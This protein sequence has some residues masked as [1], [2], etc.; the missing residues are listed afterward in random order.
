MDQGSRIKLTSNCYTWLLRRWWL[1]LYC[2]QD[3]R[4]CRKMIN[5]DI[6]IN[7]KDLIS[8]FCLL[9]TELL[10]IVYTVQAGALALWRGLSENLKKLRTSIEAPWRRELFPELTMRVLTSMMTRRMTLT[11]NDN[12]NGDSQ[13]DDDK[14]DSG[15]PFDPRESMTMIRMIRTGTMRVMTHAMTTRMTLV[16]LSPHVSRFLQTSPH[17]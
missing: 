8:L 14:N 4:A 9:V 15:R 1:H 12:H 7:D 17:L 10:C 3:P 2:S 13:E 6:G 16:D 5:S 11:I